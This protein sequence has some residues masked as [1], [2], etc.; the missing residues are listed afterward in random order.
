MRPKPRF[1]AAQ[2]VV[3]KMYSDKDW[4][5][6]W[7]VGTRDVTNV[8]NER[9]SIACVM[10]RGGVLQPLNAVSCLGADDALFIVGAVNSFAVD[11]IA[12]QR[13][14]GRHLN[15]T[16]FSQLPMPEGTPE[17][18][19][20]L[21]RKSVLELTYTAWDL[22][23]FARDCGDNGPP[24]CWDEARRFLIRCE[25]DAAYFHLYGIARDDVDYIMET[26][27]VVKRK[28]EAQFG[29][30]RTKRLI[31]EIYDAMQQA[32]DTGTAY[33]TRLDPS[34]GPLAHG[35]PAWRHGSV[36]SA[37]WP[38]HIHEPQSGSKSG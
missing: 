22:E 15:V 36:C 32:I 13:F 21:I 5:H 10:P 4:D 35:L 31:L 7:I 17:P 2:D 20:I 6:Y 33:Q 34:P 18:I 11:F 38:P 26:F 3:E 23:P 24:F 37:D 9:T 28:D 1:W 30:Y 16:T 25:L 8:N 27:P 12:R 14:T 19:A 29:E